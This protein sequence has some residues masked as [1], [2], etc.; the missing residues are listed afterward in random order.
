MEARSAKALKE[1]KQQLALLKLKGTVR[2]EQGAVVQ[3][4]LKRGPKQDGL[5]VVGSKGLDAIDRLTLGSVSTKLIH[6][7]ACRV[8]FFFKGT[9]S[10]GSGVREGPPV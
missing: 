7:R 2:K 10:R 9:I 8:C 5:L 3:T 6:Q 1:A 4:I